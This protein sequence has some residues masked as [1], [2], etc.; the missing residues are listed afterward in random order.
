MATSRKVC[1]V[2]LFLTCLVLEVRYAMCQQPPF[3][4]SDIVSHT[5][6]AV[7]QI[8]VSDSLGQP[9]ALG[10]GFLISQDG[11]I[12]TNYHVIK[13]AHTGIVK[14]TNGSFFPVDGVLASD[15]DKDLAILKVAG[16][17]LPFLSIETSQL[18]VGDRVVAIGSPLGLE[19]TVSDGIVSAIRDEGN[20]KWIQTTA[21]VSH[22]NSG[23]P[24]LDLKGN[25]AGVIT[26]GV[27]L[28]LGQNLNFAAA[29]NEVSTLLSQ[30]H[31][32]APLDSVGSDHLSGSTGTTHDASIGANGAIWTSVTTGHDYRLRR[33]N[34]HIYTEW[35]NLPKQLSGT[36]A[37]VRS[38]LKLQPDGKW[39]GEVHSN[40]PCV[41]KDAWSGREAVKW[42]SHQEHLEIDL[43]SDK[44]IEGIGSTWEKFECRKCEAKGTK[45]VPFTWIP[46]D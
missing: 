22:G 41:Y 20:N 12:V 29:A 42:C 45:D 7:V 37:F 39:S 33:E 46:K 2:F 31:S 4:I 3:S 23:G 8:V 5:S 1:F 13:G 25:V 26:W 10:S 36:M 11:R 14:L 40:L 27:N 32:P 28:N 38:D 21:P 6:D 43:L 15:P 35:V 19:G 16:K 24:L 9:T 17:N 30:S 34:D 44:R 18:R